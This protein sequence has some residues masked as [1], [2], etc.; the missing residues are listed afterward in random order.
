[1]QHSGWSGDV[2]VALANDP[3][4][5][6]LVSSAFA[7]TSTLSHS[8]Q[9]FKELQGVNG[10]ETLLS[11]LTTLRGGEE[12]GEEEGKEAGEG[13]GE[14]KSET[15]NGAAAGKKGNT[16]VSTCADVIRM[17][18]IMSFGAD[19]M[20][21]STLIKSDQTEVLQ[22]PEENERCPEHHNL[23]VR[24]LKEAMEK[25]G[26]DLN[27]VDNPGGSNYL[28]E[29]Q[30]LRDGRERGREGLSYRTAV[31]LLPSVMGME[32][33]KNKENLLLTKPSSKLFSLLLSHPTALQDLSVVTA[34][35]HSSEE[36]KFTNGQEISQR[37]NLT[38]V[39][40][41]MRTALEG[42]GE[43]NDANSPSDVPAAARCADILSN[44]LDEKQW[45]STAARQKML[46]TLD[47]ESLAE[48]AVQG[49]NLAP[50]DSES[51]RSFLQLLETLPTRITLS[52]GAF[53]E[54]FLF[55][56]T[57]KYLY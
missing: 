32:Y 12:E 26:G 40:R 13:K 9:V 19:A 37:Y 52:R 1:M 49:I 51:V 10:V 6:S 11:S 50:M 20:R 16:T 7:M 8:A 17:A 31:E 33:L 28:R 34:C 47:L 24:I 46:S 48:L 43:S 14:Q 35:S 57:M 45:S 30:L 22:F 38:D 39:C 56:T 15:N 5:I 4:P 54:I 42:S 27:I 29:I 55:L 21:E 2:N 18:A 25:K 44:I 41:V 23:V 36:Q 53:L 3:P